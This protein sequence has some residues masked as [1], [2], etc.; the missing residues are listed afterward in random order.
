MFLVAKEVVQPYL[1]PS[2]SVL[3]LLRTGLNDT[4]G[5]WDSNFMSQSVKRCDSAPHF[6]AI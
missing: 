6:F 2:N 3:T 5:N 1:I 4:T